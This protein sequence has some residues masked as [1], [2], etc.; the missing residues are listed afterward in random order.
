[1]HVHLLA[2]ESL[3][4]LGES[5]DSVLVLYSLFGLATGVVGDNIGEVLSVTVLHIDLVVSLSSVLLY[6]VGLIP[7]KLSCL[8]RIL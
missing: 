5:K 4:S 1:M 7:T 3:R 2:V 6:E 8:R